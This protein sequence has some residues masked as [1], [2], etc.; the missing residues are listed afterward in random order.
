[1]FSFVQCGFQPIYSEKSN[2]IKSEYETILTSENSISVKESFNSIFRNST[3]KSNYQLKINIVE[4]DLPIITNS[5]GTVAKYRIDISSY[6]ILYDTINNQEI[7]SDYSK[8]FAQ[9]EV[10]TNN[11]DTEQKRNEAKKIATSNSLQLIPIKIQNFQSRQV[12]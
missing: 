6:F 8:G 4:Q 3:K 2:I 5:D 1:M 7:F 12:E 9:Y 10:Q 11:Y